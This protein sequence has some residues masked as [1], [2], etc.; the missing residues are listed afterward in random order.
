M[1]KKLGRNHLCWCGSGKRYK[2][3]HLNR[4]E[5]EP[6]PKWEAEKCFRDAYSDKYCS[7]PD[8]MKHE[9]SGGIIKAHTVSKSSSLKQIARNGHVY[10]FILTLYNISKNNGVVPL[11]LM[12][13]KKAS[14]FTGFCSL[15]D[16]KLFSKIEDIEFTATSEQIFLIGYRS[17]S[18]E[19]FT[20][21]AQNEFQEI[22]KKVDKGRPENE[23]HEIQTWAYYH[24]MGVSVGVRDMNIHKKKFDKVLNSGDYKNVRGFVI[25]FSDILPVLC[26]GAR[27]PEID[28]LGNKL[29]DLSDRNKTPDIICFSLFASEGHSY[30]VFTWL[31]Y[32][33]RS[34]EMFIETL[35]RLSDKNIFS[36]LVRFIFQSFENIF[37][38]PVWWEHQSDT[39]RQKLIR[40]S[41]S[42]ANP[43]TIE[44]DNCLV[45]DG[46]NYGN[47]S[48]TSKYRINI[49]NTLPDI[50][51]GG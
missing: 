28:F 50:L 32:S 22:Y 31:E 39:I 41:A 34:C 16:K 25:E 14:T 10:G 47:Y 27:Y 7:C 49:S 46:I 18:R 13:I 38:E 51:D 6:T 17:L 30:A 33:D 35:N 24:S 26:S 8:S 1:G 20:K 40:R 36:A 48:V 5:E 37:I 12:G 23:Q 15:H 11:E 44:E 4:H 21:M 29:Q 45:D 42:A 2:R 3:C 9:C 19:H 43:T